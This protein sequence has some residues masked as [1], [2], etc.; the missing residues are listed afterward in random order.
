VHVANAVVI[1]EGGKPG[2]ESGLVRLEERGW[3]G[4]RTMPNVDKQGGKLQR[5]APYLILETHP[6]SC[7]SIRKRLPLIPTFVSARALT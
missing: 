3:G 5:R 4:V 6:T 1:G 2:S 7:F